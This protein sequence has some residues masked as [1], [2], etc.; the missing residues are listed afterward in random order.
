MSQIVPEIEIFGS[1]L[2]SAAQ[3]SAGP[4]V[5]PVLVASGNRVRPAQGASGGQSMGQAD[6]GGRA[7]GSDG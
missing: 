7:G 1:V 6:A 2:R 5:G 3:G 4:G